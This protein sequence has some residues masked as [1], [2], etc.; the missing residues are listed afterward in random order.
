MIPGALDLTKICKRLQK[1][2]SNTQ[3][4]ERSYKNEGYY[5]YV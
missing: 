3:Q 5:G 2:I 4:N 1:T